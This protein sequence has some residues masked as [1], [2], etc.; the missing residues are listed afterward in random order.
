MGHKILLRLRRNGIRFYE[1][2]LRA[3]R[4]VR[5]LDKEGDSEMCEFEEVGCRSRDDDY[6]CEFGYTIKDNHPCDI[7]PYRT[8]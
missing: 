3:L 1:G 7:C 2:A 4:D 8:W 6:C 5:K